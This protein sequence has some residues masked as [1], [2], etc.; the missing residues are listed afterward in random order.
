MTNTEWN[1]GIKYL[2]NGERGDYLEHEG[3]TIEIA[4]MCGGRYLAFDWNGEVCGQTNEEWRAM[5]FLK[6]G[7][8]VWLK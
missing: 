4:E 8:T 3:K 5:A 7:N 1:E 2:E 6:D